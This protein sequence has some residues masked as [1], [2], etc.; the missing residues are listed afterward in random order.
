MKNEWKKSQG[1]SCGLR[2]GLGCPGDVGR[3][4]DAG[5][6]A[7]GQTEGIWSRSMTWSDLRFSAC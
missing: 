7:A 3:L 6:C 4:K 2:E 1:G 5:F